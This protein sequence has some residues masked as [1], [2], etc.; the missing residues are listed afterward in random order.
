MANKENI[1]IRFLGAASTVT[2]SK[3]LVEAGQKNILIDC[4]LFQGLKELRELNWQ[5]L[6]FPAKK[7]TDVILTHAHLDH[8]GYLPRL[9]KEGFKGNIYCTPPTYEL[10]K[11]VLLDSAKIQMEDAEYANRKGF[12]KHK[13]ALPL[14]NEEDVRHCLSF[15]LVKK[16]ERWIEISKHVRFR[17]KKSGHILGSSYI[18]LFLDNKLFV[19]SGD[20]GREGSLIQLPVDDLEEADYLIM[21]STYGNRLHPDILPDEPLAEIIN[22]ALL[23]GGNILIPAFA[24]ERS[25]ELLILIHRLKK[26]NKIPNV[27]VIL[28]SPMAVEATEILFKY[29][30]WHKVSLDEINE[31]STEVNL[32]KNIKDSIAAINTHFPKIVIASSGMATGG[33]VLIYLKAWLEDHRNTIILTG[34]Q[35]AGTRGRSLKEGAKVLKIH[36]KDYNVRAKVA[37]FPFLS[38]HSD[39]KGLINWLDTLKKK[40]KVVFLNHGEKEASESLKLSLEGFLKT[41]VIVPSLNQVFE[42]EADSSEL[43]ING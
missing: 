43:E 40:P 15:F 22:E 21:E 28:D 19:F 6:A 13:P 16:D 4:G 14:Y 41:K 32:I 1:K 27:P 7:I 23:K 9:V 12:S 39:K 42:V 29:T 36:G 26:H 38:G 5:P 10:A 33:R 3:T 25:Q 20:L 31:I 8:V 17:F 37:E 30:S 34:F 2:G 11:L 18:E 24:V 35:A